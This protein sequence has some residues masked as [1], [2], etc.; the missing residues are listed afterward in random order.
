MLPEK[1]RSKIAKQDDASALVRRLLTEQAFGQWKRYAMAFA[2]MGLGAGCTAV[3]A[4]LIG[5]V[6]NAAYVDKNLAGIVSLA[7]LTAVLFLIKAIATYSHTL[8]LS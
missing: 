6:I 4:Y 2:L 7:I 1:I 3:C 5:D 8:M